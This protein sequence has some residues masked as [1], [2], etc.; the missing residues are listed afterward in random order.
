MS[1][2]ITIARQPILDADQRLLG[3]ELL[4]RGDAESGEAATAQVI[5]G[6]YSDIG[7]EQ[8]VGGSLAFINVTRDLLLDIDPL[9]FAPDRVV[10]ELL[11][12]QL[13]DDALLDRLRR[14]RA[15]GFRL[16]LDDFR[17]SAQAE[18]LLDLAD[19]VKV[20][21][22]DGGLAH[23]QH[24]ADLL[25]GRV[26]LLA[27]KVEDHETFAACAAMGYELFQ[28]YF[29]CKPQ[30]VTAEQIPVSSASGAALAAVARLGAED[31]DRDEIEQIVSTDPGLSLRLLRL[32]NS[33]AFPTRNPVTTVHD[34][35]VMLGERLLRHWV[36]LLALASVD[37]RCDALIPTALTRARTLSRLVPDELGD[38]AFSVGLLSV[39]DALLDRPMSHALD[40]LPLGDTVRDALIDHDGAIGHLLALLQTHEREPADAEL[41]AAYT[42]AIT[43]SQQTLIALA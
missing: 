22:L 32:L 17:Y 1:N 10:L 6:A 7:I 15:E 21:V 31:C 26:R 33:A 19:H 24:H 13:I 35:I 28:G 30:N 8:L 16:A 37:A 5:V 11:E 34:A 25:R 9:P 40:G 20:D 29:F 18:P 36:R 2:S 41:S 14:L 27:E 42:E 23:A 3:Y 39:A 43:W 38:T 12:D 4:H